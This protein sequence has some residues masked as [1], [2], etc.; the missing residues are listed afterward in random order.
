MGELELAPGYQ[1]V[2]AARGRPGNAQRGVTLGKLVGEFGANRSLQF[3]H[4]RQVA[5][6]PVFQQRRYLNRARKLRTGHQFPAKGRE[7]PR[8]VEI[9][10]GD[11]AVGCESA[12]QGA[13]GNSVKIRQ[14]AP[15]Y[16]AQTVQVEVCIAHLQRI[17]RPLDQADVAAQGFLP[18]KQL[19][20]A[21][22]AAVAIRRGHAGHVRVQIRGAVSQSGQRE[23]EAH[24]PPAVKSAQYLSPGMLGDHKNRVRHDLEISLAPDLPFKRHAGAELFEPFTGAHYDLVAHRFPARSADAGRSLLCSAAFA[25]SHSDSISS[26]DTSANLRPEASAIPSMAR[27]REENLALVRFSAISGST[28]K[29]RARFTAANRTSPTSS[30]TCRADRP[31]RA[32][33]SSSS[34]SCS[35]R[36]TP[37]TLAQSNPMREARRVN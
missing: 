19:E 29:N 25:R 2:G 28:F 27:N 3:L 32:L 23:R 35:F 16:G 36:T 4:L 11:Q 31:A 8:R 17:E 26:R 1:L 12:V 10:L 13:A 5:R 15:G 37:S 18:L 20:H 9:P 22:Y 21:A 7:H 6:R 30:S 14:V 24:Q 33:P 34:S